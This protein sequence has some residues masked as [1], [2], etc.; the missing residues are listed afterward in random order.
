MAILDF[1]ASASN[2]YSFRTVKYTRDWTTWMGFGSSI[3]KVNIPKPYNACFAFKCHD[4]G[5]F[6]EK[7]GYEEYWPEFFLLRRR[8]R[9]RSTSDDVSS[10]R[11][12]APATRNELC[13]SN[14]IIYRIE[15]IEVQLWKVR[16]F[17]IKLL[18]N[19][20][21]TAHLSIRS[22]R[23]PTICEGMPV[24]ESNRLLRTLVVA[25]LVSKVQE[26]STDA[27][28]TCRTVCLCRLRIFYVSMS[29]A[30]YIV[31]IYVT[32]SGRMGFWCTIESESWYLRISG[33][34]MR[35]S[36]ITVAC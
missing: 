22:L 7:N 11:I 28:F 6:A 26:Y 12:A 29:F 17:V 14:E 34:V 15:G 20:M 36:E 4:F 27:K 8:Q 32:A 3:S 33:G 19:K 30:S 16:G 9:I 23:L 24:G 31:L 13:T 18:N 2:Q 10:K 21:H 5:Y 1:S 35:V 25:F